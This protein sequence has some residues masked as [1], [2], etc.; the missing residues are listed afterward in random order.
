MPAPSI[1]L[2]YPYR[3]T[4]TLSPYASGEELGKAVRDALK[5]NRLDVFYDK[6]VLPGQVWD[7]IARRELEVRPYVVV[8]L[9]PDTL[10]TSTGVQ[11]EL[12]SALQQR[13]KIIPLMLRGFSVSKDIPQTFQELAAFKGVFF[14]P[15]HLDKDIN[16]IAKLLRSEGWIRSFFRERPRVAWGTVLAIL[17]ALLA[18]FPE[19]SRTEW[20]CRIGIISTDQ[21]IT[22]TPTTPAPAPVT[23]DPANAPAITDSP[24][25]V[26]ATSVSLIPSP[27]DSSPAIVIAPTATPTP[28]TP[29]PTTPARVTS[30]GNSLTLIVDQDSFTLFVPQQTDLTGWRFVVVVNGN[31]RSYEL[32]GFFTGLTLTNGIVEAGSCFWLTRNSG[33]PRLPTVCADRS[34]LFN[35]P[36]ADVDVFWYDPLVANFRVVEVRRDTELIGRC[37]FAEA[38]CNL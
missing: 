32:S 36:V 26:T 25:S 23:T 7:E 16:Q 12:V 18:I 8:V 2:S 5:A 38:E 21:C 9:A 20:F 37:T 19:K 34:R 22:V 6:D 29:I 31:E 4:A 15:P 33:D 28:P 14:D 1:Y 11:N 30:A 3:T 10:H 13:K 17:L 27:T 24:Q 35:A